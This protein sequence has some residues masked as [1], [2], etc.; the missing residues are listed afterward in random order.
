MLTQVQAF[1]AQKN[2]VSQIIPSAGGKT[3]FYIKDGSS[4]VI[5]SVVQNSEGSYVYYLGNNPKF[6]FKDELFQNLK[7]SK[8]TIKKV[9]DSKLLSS[10]EDEAL[11]AKQGFDT[12]DLGQKTQ[13]RNYDFSDEAQ[14]EYN[15]QKTG[16]TAAPVVQASSAPSAPLPVISKVI[17]NKQPKQKTFI[18]IPM[19]PV[20]EPISTYIAPENKQALK[21]GVVYVPSGTSF[22]AS[23]QST[24]DS[25]SLEKDDKVTATL[26]SDFI[27]HGLLVAPAGSL[28]YG[29]AAQVLHPTCAYGNGGMELNFYQILT[30]KGTQINISSDKITLNAAVSNRAGKIS[31]NVLIGVGVGVL[32]GLLS[33]AMS[34]NSAS[35]WKGAAI[36]AA[37]GTLRAATHKGENVTIEPGT[38]LKI[39]LN[40]PVNISPYN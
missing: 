1:L 21:G 5:I 7:N 40:K 11:L 26:D 23:L 14:S 35:I 29:K 39:N 3:D 20:T 31:K 15:A 37:G 13:K 2:V 19:K 12:K 32:G 38:P 4:F 28:L 17:N 30:P 34:G 22:A 9:S 6:D 33:C 18:S 36:G 8:I 25:A 16:Q 27:Y 24:V 10:F